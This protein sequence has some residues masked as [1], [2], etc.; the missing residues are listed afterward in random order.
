MNA[1]KKR[2]LLPLPARQLVALLE[3]AAQHGVE[4]LL[5][6]SAHRERADRNIVNSRIGG[7]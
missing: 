2:D 1:R 6:I 3:P 7:T 5:R 4:L